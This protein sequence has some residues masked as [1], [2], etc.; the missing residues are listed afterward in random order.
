MACANCE[1]EYKTFVKNPLL[2][3]GQQ[4]NK[5]MSE[6]SKWSDEGNAYFTRDGKLV[7]GYRCE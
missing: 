2:T 5:I 6:I 4:G 1:L 3:C 7:F